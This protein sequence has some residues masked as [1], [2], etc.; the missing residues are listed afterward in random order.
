MHD[1]ELG[2]FLFDEFLRI[3][4]FLFITSQC[5]WYEL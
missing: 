4:I 1:G 3:V 2:G 5:T